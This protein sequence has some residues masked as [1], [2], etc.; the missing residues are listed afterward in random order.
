MAEGASDGEPA[1]M[2][3]PRAAADERQAIVRE[4]DRRLEDVTN[5]SVVAFV[6]LERLRLWIV[7]RGEKE[8]ET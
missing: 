1:E 4:I 2:T 6:A 8:K 7:L 5:R 3:D